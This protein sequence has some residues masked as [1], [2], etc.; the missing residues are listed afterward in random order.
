M[1]ILQP[2]IHTP[3]FLAMVVVLFQVEEQVLTIF[4][5][6]LKEILVQQFQL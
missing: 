1:A 2:I 5:L 6:T 4:L 3:N